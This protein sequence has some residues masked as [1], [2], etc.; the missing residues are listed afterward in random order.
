RVVVE[1]DPERVPLEVIVREIERVEAQLCASV[2]FARSMHTYPGDREPERRKWV[3]L[4][5]DTM[6]LGLST[7]LRLKGVAQTP[8]DI[9]F[10]AIAAV[11]DGIPRIKKSMEQGVSLR[12]ADLTLELLKSAS[13]LAVRGEA[14]P[15]SALLSHALHLREWHARRVVWI[16]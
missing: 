2:R 4:V 3:E 1:R 11:L 16:D 14:G 10:A 13:M 12:A 6:S 8:H 9:D 15:L 5:A 7:A